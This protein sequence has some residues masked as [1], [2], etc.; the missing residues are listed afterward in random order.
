MKKRR[1]NWQHL[2]FYDR[3][4]TCGVWCWNKTSVDI[5]HSQIGL[6]E[7]KS[8]KEKVKLTKSFNLCWLKTYKMRYW[9][10]MSSVFWYH[11]FPIILIIISLS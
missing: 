8:E 1:W 2:L 3:L 5:T 7:I 4:K 6:F 10:T 9:N 11:E